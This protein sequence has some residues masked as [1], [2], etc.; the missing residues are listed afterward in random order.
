MRFEFLLPSL[1]FLMLTAC[2]SPDKNSPQ[3]VNKAP[4]TLI[5]TEYS[6][7]Q[8]SGYFH[9]H[10]GKAINRI[11]AIENEYFRNYTSKG[12]KYYGTQWRSAS[13]AADPWSPDLFGEYQ[14]EF[15]E[16]DSMHCTIYAVEAL[17]AGMGPAFDTLEAQHRKIWKDRE[18][19]GWS[20][21]Y[22]LVKNWGWKAYLILDSG[23][24][25]FNQC[26]RAFRR[27]KSY[28]VWKQPDIPLE[29]VFIRGKDNAE[30]AALL[31]Q[32]EFGWGFSHQGIHTWI[33]RFKE[34]KECNWFGAPA[35]KWEVIS[36][37]LF[38]RKP[39]LDFWDYA[40]H[41]I[42]FP[43]PAVSKNIIPDSDLGPI[44]LKN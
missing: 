21:G 24:V 38:K 17:K 18:H 39:F 16:V 34:L 9:F 13:E 7:T 22:L 2:H 3:S 1:F 44:E 5:Y 4:D 30:I 20:I 43:P 28:P 25:E 29:E 32:N 36:D 26:Q 27:K 33:T 6:P 10:P 23:S 37:P 12:S 31:A 11:A 19:A 35:E 14:N 42:V 8:L 40:S 41:V 15:G